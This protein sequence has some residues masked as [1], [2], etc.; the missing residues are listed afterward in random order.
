MHASVSTCD[1][2]PRRTD[3]SGTSYRGGS[4]GQ[5]GGLHDQPCRCRIEGSEKS[6]VDE[7]TETGVIDGR[8]LA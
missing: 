1:L 4:S 6:K 8:G 5:S 2:K 7:R 3:G